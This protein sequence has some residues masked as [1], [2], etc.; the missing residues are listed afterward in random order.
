MIKKKQKTAIEKLSP[1]SFEF[2]SIPVLGEV[3]L[4]EEDWPFPHRISIGELIQNFHKEDRQTITVRALDHALSGEGIFKN[5]LLTVSLKTRPRDGDI[6]AVVFGDKLFIRKIYFQKG[7][8]R[9]DTSEDR[10]APLIIDEQTPEVKIL[11]KV[12]M[13]VREL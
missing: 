13:V 10:P 3:H 1:E 5:D 9:L 4:A 12:T 6:A 8:I 2:F 11:G 7:L